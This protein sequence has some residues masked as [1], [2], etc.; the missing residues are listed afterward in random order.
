MAAMRWRLMR[1]TAPILVLMDIPMPRVDGLAT[2]QQIRRFDASARVLMVADYD[3]EGL[4]HSAREAGTLG[5]ALN[6]ICPTS[7]R[8]CG[9]PWQTRIAGAHLAP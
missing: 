4:R 5:Y 3:S 8:P 9:R 6:T 2:T 1:R 7:S